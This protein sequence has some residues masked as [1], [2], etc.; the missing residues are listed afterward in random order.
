MPGI[1]PH[2]DYPVGKSNRYVSCSHRIRVLTEL[3]LVGKTGI[4][5]TDAELN[6]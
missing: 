1:V 2:T 3:S 6:T 5:K 4:K